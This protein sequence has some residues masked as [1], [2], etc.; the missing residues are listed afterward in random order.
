MALRKQTRNT[1]NA[2]IVIS[3]SST[4]TSERDGVS[5]LRLRLEGSTWRHLDC[6]A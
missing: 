2:T 4:V 1:P 5:G 6:S 3:W